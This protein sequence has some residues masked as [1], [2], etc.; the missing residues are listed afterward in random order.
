MLGWAPTDQP[1]DLSLHR[2]FV[3][4]IHPFCVLESIINQR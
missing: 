1:F 4:L 3:R 2:L